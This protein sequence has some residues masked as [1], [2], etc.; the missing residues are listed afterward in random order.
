MIFS[1]IFGFILETVFS[2]TSYIHVYAMDLFG[3]DFENDFLLAP[4]FYPRNP[5]WRERLNTFD[6]L[7]LTSFDQLR[8]I[9]QRRRL[10]TV[11]LLIKYSSEQLLSTVD[12][13]IK[14]ACYVKKKNN[15]FNI[16]MSL[17]KLVTTR[18]STVLS[19]PP[20]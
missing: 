7:V 5:Y 19:L 12:L 16:K 9:L 20:Q 1:N 2:Y 4:R 13:L 15:I 10:S 6:P 11:D 8:L 14:V 17:S 3:D 18:R